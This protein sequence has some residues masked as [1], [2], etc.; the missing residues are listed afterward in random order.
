[1][2]SG[3][4]D[5]MIKVSVI[6]PAYNAERYIATCL[7]SLVHQTLPDMEIIVIDDASSDHTVSIIQQYQKK[8]K[9]IA[10]IRHK[11]NM[12]IGKSR[13][14]GI[15]KA[16]GKY[17]GFVDSDDFVSLDTYFAYYHFCEKN[18]LSLLY[19]HYYKVMEERAVLFQTDSIS[20][21][22]VRKDP[23]ILCKVDYGPCNK[24]FLKE[25][26]DAHTIRF[27]ENIKYED[28]PFVAKSLFH[29]KKVGHLDA[30]YYYYR[31]HAGSETTTMDTR[32]FDIFQCLD[33]VN[34]YYAKEKKVK[35]GLEYLN[36]REVT[37]YM[38]RQR[39]Q[40][41]KKIQKDFVKAGFAYLDT[42]F[43]L[44]KQNVYYKQEPLWKRFIKNHPVCM[45]FYFFFYRMRRMT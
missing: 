16:R 20:F 27:A 4:C 31:I 7:D 6:V 25:M 2:N 37:R 35:Q 30:P 11:K 1:M 14:D 17:I 26:I 21:T 36:I 8:Y 19:S 23:S 29:A 40:K 38:L 42:H 32:V 9:Q 43:P 10:L 39:Y 13:N 41:E 22:N 28:M 18:H 3:R 5:T 34:E 24:I 15:S 12:G 45:Q 33:M 44:W